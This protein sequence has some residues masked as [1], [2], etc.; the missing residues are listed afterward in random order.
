MKKKKK[1]HRHM[2]ISFYYRGIKLVTFL[3]GG[4]FKTFKPSFLGLFHGNFKVIS[5]VFL[6]SCKGSPHKK[7]TEK[8]VLFL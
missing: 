3:Q 2:E 7:K 1:N 5:N 4:F 6:V 8:L